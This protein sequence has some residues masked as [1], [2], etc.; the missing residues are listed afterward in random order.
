M[1]S[2][3]ASLVPFSISPTSRQQ[4]QL[5]V[6]GEA[7][8]Y[9][10]CSAG[11]DDG[12]PE[13]WIIQ[14]IGQTDAGSMPVG[15]WTDSVMTSP[16]SDASE[17]GVAGSSGADVSMMMDGIDGPL[18]F[19]LKQWPPKQ[20]LQGIDE[21]SLTD[22]DVRPMVADASVLVPEVAGSAFTA[23]TAAAAAAATAATGATV[24]SSIAQSLSY[25]EDAPLMQSQPSISTAVY[26]L[27]ASHQ[28]RGTTLDGTLNDVVVAAG[29]YKFKHCRAAGSD[30]CGCSD[31]PKANT[32]AAARLLDSEL[33]QRNSP[34]TPSTLRR[35]LDRRSS[36]V[37]TDI[38]STSPISAASFKGL[39]VG[40]ASIGARSGGGD[41]L[42]MLIQGCV[43]AASASP[44]TA[45]AGA[46][47]TSEAKQGVKQEST[48][49][50]TQRATQEAAYPAD[51]AHATPLA[52]PMGSAMLAPTDP[53]SGKVRLGPAVAS[54]LMAPPSGSIPAP[55]RPPIHRRSAKEKMRRHRVSDVLKRLQKAIPLSW[56]R[57]KYPTNLTSRT[58]IAS[59]L[60]AA[61]E[62]IGELEDQK[63]QLSHACMYQSLSGFSCH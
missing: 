16:P 53:L 12:G 55:G 19:P 57:Q 42:H 59:L 51:R 6:T 25:F 61:A 18:D 15:L 10:T 31:D 17:P 52:Q 32:P 47:A 4:Q 24:D 48:Q 39:P 37:G 44:A 63:V 2:A 11:S 34:P 1:D 9:P 50:T 30:A 40:N 22:L 20:W 56:L 33:P 26:D 27:R 54:A 29:G 8:G 60:H 28:P 46:E 5:Q 62:F 38:E 43:A 58:D 45:V 21:S 49:E 41:S 3:T 14:Q 36:S 13:A 7:W 23:A 35:Q